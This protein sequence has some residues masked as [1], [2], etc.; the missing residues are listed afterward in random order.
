MTT[1]VGIELATKA[2]TR[3]SV[4]VGARAEKKVDAGQGR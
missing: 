2:F 3:Q 1:D 4:T